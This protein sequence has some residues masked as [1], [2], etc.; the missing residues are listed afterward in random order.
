MTPLSA[1]QIKR[2]SGESRWPM[3]RPSGA[4]HIEA[5]KVQQQQRR[6]QLRS[7]ISFSTAG[8]TCEEKDSLCGLVSKLKHW[9]VHEKSLRWADTNYSAFIK[10]CF[11]SICSAAPPKT[12]WVFLY[13]SHTPFIWFWILNLPCRSKTL[14]RKCD[15]CSWPW[16]TAPGPAQHS[17]KCHRN[18][19]CYEHNTTAAMA[20]SR[21]VTSKPGSLG[22]SSKHDTCV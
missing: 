3:K 9:T 19:A 7:K 16:E 8:V 21:G 11:V 10:C 1:R 17:T 2:N 12:E 6:Q 22:S 4:L 14:T 15:V 20:T 18:Q 5:K 13:S